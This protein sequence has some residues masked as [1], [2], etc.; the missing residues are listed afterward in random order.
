MKGL[1]NNS[2][3]ILVNSCDNFDD[4]WDPFFTLFSKYWKNYQGKLYLNTEYKDYNCKNLDIVPLRVC[5]KQKDAHRVAWS[6][7]LIRA[8]EKIE[9]EVILYLQEDYF[10]RGN[11]N[12]EIIESYVKLMNDNNEVDCIHLTDQSVLADLTKPGKYKNLR[13]VLK[14]Q[15]YRVSCQAALWRKEVLLSYL[16]SYESAWQF[17]EFA[18]KRSQYKNHN[19]YVVDSNWVIKDKHEIIPYIFTGIVQGRWKKEV[20]P[21]FNS[22]GIQMDFSIRGFVENEINKPLFF[23][24]KNQFNRMIVKWFHFKEYILK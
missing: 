9:E 10:F 24:F 15:R 17:E 4:C 20:V 23:K 3:S 21:L 18:S 12:V 19:F 6:E 16:R 14:N 13:P 11:V 1:S 5:I 7:C 8:L 2:F 22:N